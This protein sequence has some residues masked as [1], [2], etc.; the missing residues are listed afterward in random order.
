MYMNDLDRIEKYKNS[1]RKAWAYTDYNDW[2]IKYNSIM[3]LFAD[4]FAEEFLVDLKKL[5]ETNVTLEEIARAFYNPARIYRI[6][7]TVIFG[8]KRRCIPLNEQREYVL[9]LLDIVQLMKCGSEFNESGHNIIWDSNILRKF[10]SDHEF[11]AA[12]DQSAIII[13][14]FCG[15]IW[16][17]TE[18]IFFRAHDVT[19]EIHGPYHINES[20]NILLVREYLNLNKVKIW[21]GISLLPC[22]KIVIYT[23]YGADV[24]LSIDAYNHLYLNKGNY[25]K[26]L[27]NY[28]IEIDGRPA[29]INEITSLITPMIDVINRIHLWAKTA[30]WQEIAQKY[31]EIYWYR[32]KPLRDLLGKSWELPEEIHQLILHGNIDTRMLK[33]L[34]EKEIDW[35]ISTLI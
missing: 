15:I 34:N 33:P 9:R 29:H 12:D 7:N 10:F 30:N 16:A 31:A 28:Y 11:I 4:K 18:A 26:D 32:K 27:K 22:D 3:H 8:M 6:I 2:P 24:S 14:Q 5:K 17:Y 35:L 25:I 21:P 1:L 20:G 13:Q 23:E 19:K